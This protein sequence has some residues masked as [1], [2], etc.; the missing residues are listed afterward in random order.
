MHIF[1]D[2]DGL[3]L[4]IPIYAVAFFRRKFQHENVQNQLQATLFTKKP[5]SMASET[6]GS[7]LWFFFS[8]EHCCYFGRAGGEGER[9]LSNIWGF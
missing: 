3:F 5:L 2:W 4:K 1:K 9:I 8:F 6:C 7:K